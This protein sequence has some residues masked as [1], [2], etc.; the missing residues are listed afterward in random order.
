VKPALPF[1]DRWWVRFILQSSLISIAIY[2]AIWATAGQPRL[3]NFIVSMM[4]M[5]AAMY[6]LQTY[7]AKRDKNLAKGSNEVGP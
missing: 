5:M 2:T 1:L 4:L 6:P 3:T 7:W